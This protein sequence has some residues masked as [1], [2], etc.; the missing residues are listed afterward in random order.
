MSL[1]FR[2]MDLIIRA[3]VDTLHGG[4][5]VHFLNHWMEFGKLA[6]GREAL[7]TLLRGICTDTIAAD[8]LVTSGAI[9]SIDGNIVAVSTSVSREHSVWAGVELL[10]LGLDLSKRLV[11]EE[12]WRIRVRH[13]IA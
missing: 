10:H 12:L 7:A 13:C 11:D 9:T 3:L 6:E 1:V 8:H 2:Q 4:P 5:F